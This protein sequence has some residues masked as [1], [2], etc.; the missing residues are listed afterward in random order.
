M[1]KQAISI[2]LIISLVFSQT[3]AFCQEKNKEQQEK[4]STPINSAQLTVGLTGIVGELKYEKGLITDKYGVSYFLLK[5]VKSNTERSIYD[6][7][8]IADEELD[9]IINQYQK[10]EKNVSAIGKVT[11]ACMGISLGLVVAGL[12]L[13]LVGDSNDPNVPD[14]VEKEVE[15][16]V[17]KDI[18][19]WGGIGFLGSCVLLIPLGL[20]AKKSSNY[21]QK[22]L[23]DRH[24]NAV[25]NQN[26]EPNVSMYFSVSAK[27]VHNRY[28]PTISL[29]ITF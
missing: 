1:I 8:T 14:D 3:Y 25:K 6:I 18:M 11:G 21:L 29:L 26:I 2:L 9:G 27:S 28:I 19:K 7:G 15:N 4:T 24:N 13:A 22:E 16:E 17:G 5:N 10:Y 12:S 20:S 23:I